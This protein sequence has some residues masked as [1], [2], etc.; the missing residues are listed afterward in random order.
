MNTMQ[1]D[2][3]VEDYLHRLEAAAAKVLTRGRA[4][5]LVGEIRSHIHDALQADGALDEAGVRNVLERIGPPEEI[6]LAALDGSPSAPEA[7]EGPAG[8]GA[9]ETCAV[10]VLGIGSL[11][12]SVLATALGIALVWIS[13]GWQTRDKLIATALP[14]TLGLFLPLLGMLAILL[15]G[16][17][18]LVGLLGSLETLIL[19]GGAGG[20]AGLLGALYLTARLP[21]ET[22][23]QRKRRRGLQIL[24]VIAGLGLIAL[25]ALGLL[26]SNSYL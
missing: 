9:L 23:A 11:L 22:P 3:L 17:G 7:P 21:A 1:T 2:R 4:T 19:L 5:E 14:F 8:F 16:G 15:G 25:V 24:L 20:L 12:F 13:N 26:T 6:A 18:D 10:L